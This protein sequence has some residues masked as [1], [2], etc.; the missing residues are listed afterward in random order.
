[1]LL[2]YYSDVIVYD[3]CYDIRVMLYYKIDVIV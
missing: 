3:W 1:M 2:L